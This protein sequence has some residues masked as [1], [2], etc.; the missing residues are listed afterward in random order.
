MTFLPKKLSLHSL[1]ARV[2]NLERY[3]NCEYL[4]T[5]SSGGSNLDLS[6]VGKGLASFFSINVFNNCD[7]FTVEVEDEVGG[8]LTVALV[9]STNSGGV[10]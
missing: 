2:G 1:T 8:E 5:T 10:V 3:K 9:I 7:G 6:I 4:F